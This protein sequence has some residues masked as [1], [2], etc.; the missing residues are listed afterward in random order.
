MFQFII[1]VDGFVVG[2]HGAGCWVLG[3]WCLTAWLFDNNASNLLNMVTMVAK[4]HKILFN[5][6]EKRSVACNSFVACFYVHFDPIDPYSI[7]I[8]LSFSP[9]RLF[10]TTKT[11]LL[12]INRTYIFLTWLVHALS[13]LSRSKMYFK[14]HA[15]DFRWF[16][17]IENVLQSIK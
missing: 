12:C 7:R 14:T 2:I 10:S 16:D 13:T 9:A 8:A 17:S 11:Y 5:Q 3:A 15:D 1:I 6:T 4:T